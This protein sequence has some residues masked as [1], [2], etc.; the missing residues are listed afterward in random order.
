M[1]QI[2]KIERS[3]LPPEFLTKLIN[4]AK[5]FEPVEIVRLRTCNATVENTLTHIILRSY[6][7]IVAVIEC[8]SGICFDVLR[9]VY[10]Y[11]AT[12]AQH[13]AKFIKD[14]NPYIAKVIRVI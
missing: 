5:H 2:T 13:I 1:K 12:S 14:Y 7:T 6:G 4:D 9:V 11:T 3:A 10:G 8:D